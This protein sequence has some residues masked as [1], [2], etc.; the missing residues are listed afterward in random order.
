MGMYFVSSVVLIRMNMPLEYRTIIT[1]VL[2][3][4][5]FN[6]YHRWF[7]VIFLVSALSSIGFL[8]VVR[9]QVSNNPID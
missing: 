3:D 2:G 7:D 9:K 6:F 5:Q 4:L 1:E 8:Y